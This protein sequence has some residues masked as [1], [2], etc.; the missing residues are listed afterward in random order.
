MQTTNALITT[1]T[2]AGSWL[3]R[4]RWLAIAGVLIGAGTALALSQQ[5]LA[6]ATLVPLLYVLPCAAMMFM[7]MKGMNHG[8]PAGAAT[9]AHNE[10]PTNN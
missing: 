8:K 1:P 4:W 2:T 7:C 9:T 6:V 3:R 10:P 5:W